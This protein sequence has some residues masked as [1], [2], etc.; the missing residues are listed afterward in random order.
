MPVFD[1]DAID[2][3]YD[4][5]PRSVV[6]TGFNMKTVGFAREYH[7]HRKAEILLIMRGSAMC[8]SADG[9]WIVP[10]QCA[11][12]VPGGVPHNATDK[13]LEGYC[14]FVDPDAAPFMPDACCTVSVSPLLRELIKH[15][16][17][18]S[19]HY[20]VDG[21]EGKIVSVL[22]DQLS[23]APIEELSFPMPK[24][25]RL[26]KIAEKLMETPSKRLTV[27]EWSRAIGMSERTLA[28]LILAETGM[29]FGQWRQQLHIIL[30][31]QWLTGGASVQAVSIDLG[32]E[33]ASSFVYMFRKTMGA[34]PARYIQTRGSL[35]PRPASQGRGKQE[36]GKCQV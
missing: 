25:S 9:L 6:A 23:K 21:P 7:I 28:R 22:L 29:S 36:P 32:Y 8:E 33:S 14:L 15:C 5:I 1:V 34:S 11:L 13:P 30:A 10:P 31:L 3:V 4:Q 19:P 16:A 17:T 24:D 27:T 2:F 35:A 20:D 26:R 12:W 18:M